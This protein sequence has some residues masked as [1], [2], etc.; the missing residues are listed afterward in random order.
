LSSG[1]AKNFHGSVAGRD[2]HHRQATSLT[3]IN[4]GADLRRTL[5]AVGQ[6][7]IGAHL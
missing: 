4:S 6:P 2:Q 1:F 7:I 3:A 5:P